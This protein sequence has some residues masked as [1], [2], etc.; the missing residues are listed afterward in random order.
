MLIC[1]LE[2]DISCAVGP[3]I[4]YKILAEGAALCRAGDL[5]MRGNGSYSELFSD[6]SGNRYLSGLTGQIR[7]KHDGT[8]YVVVNPSTGRPSSYI[9]G[10]M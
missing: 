4:A 6:G 5:V 1:I 8:G 9:Q 2:T 7:V 10:S 3:W